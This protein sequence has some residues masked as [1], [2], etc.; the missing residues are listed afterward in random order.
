MANEP[1][2]LKSQEFLGRVVAGASVKEIVVRIAK[3]SALLC[4]VWNQVAY[5]PAAPRG[6]V[7]ASDGKAAEAGTEAPCGA[8][9]PPKPSAPA[10]KMIGFCPI[11]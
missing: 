7:A 3:G 5:A 4:L 6:P 2:E 10:S 1:N 9:E 8:P 11:E